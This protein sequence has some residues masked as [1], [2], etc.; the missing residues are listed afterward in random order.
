MKINDL[1]AKL[2]KIREKHGA[3]VEVAGRY[4]HGNRFAYAPADK[5]RIKT[6]S[7]KTKPMIYLEAYFE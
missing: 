5:V 4:I 7:P 3:Q 2:E 1:I 6:L